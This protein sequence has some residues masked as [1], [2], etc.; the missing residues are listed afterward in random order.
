MRD[1]LTVRRE[2]VSADPEYRARFMDASSSDARITGSCVALG[3]C[4]LI[5]KILTVG[6]SH[7]A[8]SV[9]GEIAKGTN[10]FRRRRGPGRR[11][12]RRGPGWG[13][14]GARSGS[15]SAAG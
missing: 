9:F 6:S 1:A 12:G 10:A 4:Y 5:G 13:L 15:G 7:P 11:H 8:R 14:A 2:E 3:H